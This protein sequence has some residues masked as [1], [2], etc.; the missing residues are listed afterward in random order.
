MLIDGQKFDILDDFIP[1]VENV[2]LEF[3]SSC[4]R[5]ESTIELL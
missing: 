4:E 1:R 3:E 5:M 2:E